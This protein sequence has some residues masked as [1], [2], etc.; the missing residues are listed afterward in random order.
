MVDRS[1]GKTKSLKKKWKIP[2]L[3]GPV[4]SFHDYP[5]T[6]L[7]PCFSQRAVDALRDVLEP[8]GELLPAKTKIEKVTYMTEKSNQ[9]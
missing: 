3:W 8:N 2:E 9:G 4:P 6:E 1:I 5:A 7:V